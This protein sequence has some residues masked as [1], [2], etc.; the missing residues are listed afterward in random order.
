MA[1]QESVTTHRRGNSRAARIA[2]LDARIEAIR[3]QARELRRAE[4]A[5]RARTSRRVDTRR[6]VILGAVVIDLVRRGVISR[7]TYT[8]W[9]AGLSDR[10]RELLSLDAILGP[11]E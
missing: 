1:E 8:Q 4:R 3:E 5:A 11:V 6:K 10:D 7:E 2:A 9:V